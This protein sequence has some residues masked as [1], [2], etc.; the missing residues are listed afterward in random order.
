[1]DVL[2]R[3]NV[4]VSGAAGA[5]P[6][7]FSHGFGCDQRMWRH[8]A[9]AFT[10]AYRTVLFDHVGSGRSDLVAYDHTRYDSLSGYADDVVEICAALDLRDTVFVGHSVSAMI[11][12]LA[13]RRAPGRIGALVL[14]AP[15]P[16][17]IDDEVSGY[18]GGFSKQDIAG[19]LD[20]LDSNYLGWSQAM[21]PVIMGHPDRPELAAELEESFC[22][23]DP[24]IAGHFAQVTFLSDNRRDLPHVSVPTLVVQCSEDAIARRVVGEYVHQQISGSEL[25]V[26]DTTGHCPHLS[27]PGETIAAIR[28]FLGSS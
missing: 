12:V 22:R 18:A 8:V 9:P 7:P 21:A 11:G 14:V 5:R 17:Y 2:A 1:M 10:S 4:S 28:E 27:V 6:I 20:T 3:N 19:L 25:V 13:A 26:L 24:V 23:T 16:R 15:S